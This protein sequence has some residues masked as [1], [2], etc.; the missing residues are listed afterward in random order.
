MLLHNRVSIEG[1]RQM[2]ERR[3][4]QRWEESEKRETRSKTV[5]A[6]AK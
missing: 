3:N 4:E 2:V 1:E 6:M 5:S